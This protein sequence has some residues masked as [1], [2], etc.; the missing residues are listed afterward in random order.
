MR[1]VTIFVIFTFPI[2]ISEI[3]RFFTHRESKSFQISNMAQDRLYS[4]MMKHNVNRIY[5]GLFSTTLVSK[6]SNE[7][8]V[9]Q[10]F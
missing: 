9:V 2:G 6:V 10:E 5:F 4:Y 8:S 1:N 7:L 3:L